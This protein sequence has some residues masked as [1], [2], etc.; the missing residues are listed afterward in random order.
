MGRSLET[1]SSVGL[2]DESASPI[3]LPS[4]PR[5]PMCP[6]SK[7][8]ILDLI[9]IPV[10]PES[11]PRVSTVGSTPGRYKGC[12]QSYTSLSSLPLTTLRVDTVGDTHVQRRSDTQGAPVP[13][14]RTGFR[15]ESQTVYHPRVI[16]KQ[17]IT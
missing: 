1:G 4:S 6:G 13:S 8:R 17:V 9:G 7:D 5:T 14:G 15:D 10:D 3:P 16:Y 2:P 12:T 11:Q